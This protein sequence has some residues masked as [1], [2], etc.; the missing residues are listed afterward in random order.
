[1]YDAIMIPKNQ[2]EQFPLLS[3]LQYYFLCFEFCM[4]FMGSN[5]TMSIC[6]NPKQ[7]WKH[8]TIKEKKKIN[9]GVIHDP[10]N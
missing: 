2:A 1:M 7:L 6:L 8:N 5:D 9:N 10:K 4:T 3:I